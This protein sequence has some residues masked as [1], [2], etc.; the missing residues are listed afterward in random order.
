MGCLPFI[1]VSSQEISDNSI[2]PANQTNNT[3][4]IKIDNSILQINR[5]FIPTTF[6]VSSSL[7]ISQ[8]LTSP[9]DHYE[10]IRTMGSGSSAE[11]IKVRNKKNGFFRALKSIK[12]KEKDTLQK[13]YDEV[14]IIKLLDHPN[15]MKIYDYYLN[16][17]STI[18]LITEFIPG[19]ELFSKIKKQQIFKEEQVVR[20][21][22]QL[23]SAIKTCHDNNI[24]HRDIKPENIILYNEE[25]NK[26]K[27]IDFGTAKLLENKGKCTD[28]R[29]TPTYIA[30]EILKG[31][32]YDYKC[33]LWSAGVL[34]YIMLSGSKPFTG[35]TEEQIF[36]S[37]KKDEISFSEKE[38]KSVSENAKQLIKSLLIKDPSKRIS[39]EEALGSEWIKNN[40]KKKEN[41]NCI[42]KNEKNCEKMLENIK[43]FNHIN[44]LQL[45]SILYLIHFNIDFYSEEI[46]FLSDVFELFDLD[47]DG[48]LSFSEFQSSLDEFVKNPKISEELTKSIFS[49]FT[50]KNDPTPFLLFEEFIGIC[51]DL[52]NILTTQNIQNTF[53]VLDKTRKGKITYD[54]LKNL[55][56]D[57]D[58]KVNEDIIKS[59]FKEFGITQ[60]ESLSFP[61]YNQ[62][63]KELIK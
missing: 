28:K 54:S 49:I 19:E 1:H 57:K 58:N 32:P 56:I 47:N 37:I 36:N 23:F 30:P 2:Q 63:M 20:I 59:I 7:F 41:L 35:F 34:M 45:A 25:K 12:L 5:N 15:I 24:V 9:Y 53:M 27:L 60:E 42:F 11:V 33:D 6:R 62:I 18:D 10:N 38:W 17:S 4:S 44:K 13:S 61:A 16:P 31:E 22:T 40:N 52:K 46:I 51:T 39:A 29:G 55:L 21:M 14:E 26:I 43:K 8:F 3:S 50:D 48:R